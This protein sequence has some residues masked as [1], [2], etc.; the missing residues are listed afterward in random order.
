MRPI[1]LG[2]DPKKTALA[3]VALWDD[4]FDVFTRTMPLSLS[5][6]CSKANQWSR[7]I[8]QQLKREHDTPIWVFVEQGLVGRGG[9]KSSIIQAYVAGGLLCG[10]HEGGAARIELVNQSTWKK[11]IVGNGAAKK[12]DVARF[13]RES[14]PELHKRADSNEDVADAGLIAWYGQLFSET[15]L[16]AEARRVSRGRR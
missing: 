16:R 3:G 4:G 2:I 8:V 5:M 11:R 12:P 1:I 15:V 9:V 6:C 10:L 14:W 13:V 7:H